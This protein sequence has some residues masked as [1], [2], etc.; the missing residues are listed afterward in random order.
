M[1]KFLSFL[2]TFVMLFS[3]TMPAMAAEPTVTGNTERD[4]NATFD[5]EIA[6]TGLT[7]EAENILYD[8]ATNTYTIPLFEDPNGAIDYT[9]V[10]SGKN[11]K[12]FADAEEVL[13]KATLTMDGTSRTEWVNLAEYVANGGE[14]FTY[15]ADTGMLKGE[16][17]IPYDAKIEYQYSN[18]N[19]TNWSDPVTIECKRVHEIAVAED[20]ANGTVT[21]DKEFAAEGETVTLTVTPDEGYE[22]VWVEYRNADDDTVEAVPIEN[23]QFVMPEYNVLIYAEFKEATKTYT[24]TLPE[25]FENGAVTIEG[26]KTSFTERETVT[27][28]VAPAE[29]YELDTLTVN[30]V[31]VTANVVDGKYSFPMGSAGVKVT[32][33]FKKI[34]YAIEIGT[35]EGGSVTA[36]VE[37]AAEGDTVTLTV[38]TTGKYQLKSIAVWDAENEPVEFTETGLTVYK[39]VMPASEV[40]VEAV[41][42]EVLTTSADIA[43]GSLSFVYADGENGAEDGAWSCEDGANKITV[44][45]IGDNAFSAT[46]AYEA[47]DGFNEIS[48]AFFDNNGEEVDAI[49]GA[50]LDSGETCNF[51]LCLDGTPAKALDGVI[52]EVTVKINSAPAAESAVM[53]VSTEYNPHYEDP[54]FYTGYRYVITFYNEAGTELSDSQVYTEQNVPVPIPDGAASI[55]ITLEAFDSLTDM[56]GLTGVSNKTDLPGVSCNVKY[57]CGWSGD[58]RVNSVTITPIN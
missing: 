45:N 2:L 22:L 34:T 8:Q 49:A 36:D 19:G 18:D 20:I 41:F 50:R 54:S 11:L 21:A 51:Y 42:E 39:F 9:E 30:D 55:S 24:V 7:F 44:E 5:P 29:G 25:T 47:K 52:G 1:K 26:D 35:F 40:T 46:P 16:A 14:M 31:D 17:A 27:L 53:Y 57:S 12:Y 48:G 37:T 15:D 33:T 23:N 4:V 3:L 43:W 32:A 56:W 58:N 6:V 13:L 10:Y 38:T 28:N